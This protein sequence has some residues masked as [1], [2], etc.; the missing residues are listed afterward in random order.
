MSE[1][2]TI[3]LT[4]ENGKS[5]YVNIED[6]VSFHVN[7]KGNVVILTKYAKIPVLEKSYQLE[8]LYE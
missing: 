3:K 2:K 1:P 6:I 8:Q 7:A 5:V 4:R